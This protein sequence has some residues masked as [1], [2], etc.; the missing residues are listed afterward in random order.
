M[1]HPWIME[2]GRLPLIS[3]GFRPIKVVYI[4]NR[5]PL[6]I[7]L[8]KREEIGLLLL[9]FFPVPIELSAILAI[10]SNPNDS[11]SRLL[12]LF[13]GKDLVLTF[14]VR[15][16]RPIE[17]NLVDGVAIV[18]VDII[19]LFSLNSPTTSSP[20]SFAPLTVLSTSEAISCSSP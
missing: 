13:L 1:F 8:Y 3:W 11:I 15:Y 18:H 20:S 10:D 14:P 2:D 5:A 12:I 6:I 9:R 17:R 16:K 19:L 4:A 7:Y